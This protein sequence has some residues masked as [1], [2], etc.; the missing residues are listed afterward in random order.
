[1]TVFLFIFSFFFYAPLFE[2]LRDYLSPIWWAVLLGLL[3]GGVIDYFVPSSY[4]MKYLSGRRKRT[5]F[6][7]VILGF[8]MSACSHGILAIAMQLHKKGASTSSTI[9]FL[10]AAPWANMSITIL[11]FSFFGLKALAIIFSAILIAIITGL[12]YQ[13][14][15]A[16]GVIEG[17]RGGAGGSE[18]AGGFSI[19][20]DVRKRWAGYKLSAGGLARDAK[21]V[22]S[23]SWALAKM[24]LW[25]ILIGMIMASFV[26]AFVPA[27]LFHHYL[28]ATALGLLVTLA[29]A[30]VIEVCSEGSYPMA[31]EIFRQTG[32]FG[33]SL[34]F[35]MAG[36]ATDYTEIGLIW[37]NIGRR[38]AILLPV[39]AVPQILL[40]REIA[41]NFGT[42][43][44]PLEKCLWAICSIWFCEV[45]GEEGWGSDLS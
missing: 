24:V 32:A 14:L 16:R 28:G 19:R 9:A 23:G 34:V 25:W 10:L 2:A 13:V 41:G 4:V 6:H 1:M 36:V 29:F 5:I 27:D 30:T 45:F 35:L 18:D 26:R 15:E 3:V 11:L 37:S 31:F 33:N 39:I 7:S 8:A 40:V 22:L 12:I 38:A 43:F 42:P 44:F 20:Q 17:G 21:G